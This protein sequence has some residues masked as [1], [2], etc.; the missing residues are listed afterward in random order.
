M[1]PGGDRAARSFFHVGYNFASGAQ[2]PFLKVADN[3]KRLNN[4]MDGFSQQ[5]VFKGYQNEGHDSCWGDYQD[6]NKRAGGAEDFN[7]AIAEAD[8]MNS[9]IGIH[10]NNTGVTPEAKA[11]GDPS[12]TSDEPGWVWMDQSRILR[13]YADMLT[14]GFDDRMNQL[15]EQTPDL[16][17]VYVDCW[18]DDRWGEKKLIRNML[19]NGVEMFGTENG[20]DFIRVGAWTHHPDCASKISQFV[21]NTQRDFYNE[22]SIYWGGYWRGVSMMS[23]QHNNNINTLVEQFYTNQLPQKYLMCHEVLK[24]TNDSA[25]FEGN[26][27]S[28]NWI[29]TKDGN[30]ITDGKEKIFIPWYAEDSKTQNPDEAAKIYHWN[31]DGGKT[32]WTLPKSWSNLDNV[33]LYET[34][35][36]GKKLVETIDVAEGQVTIDAKAKT[37]YVVY[38]GEAKADTTEWSVGSPLKDTGFNSRDFS[39]WKNQEMQILRI[40]MMEMVYQSL[41]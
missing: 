26:V 39:I 36:T 32:T 2:Q 1:I 18:G 34:T 27:T 35:Q 29:I 3:M 28:G 6:V 24:Q 22:S 12:T 20:P 4:Y 17:F 14:G 10:L 19:E 40:M 8:K 13:R 9:N 11:Y 5:L 16:D 38:P 15:F 37:P 21:Y 25:I 7:V 41:R 30:K 31:K 23:W 33:Y